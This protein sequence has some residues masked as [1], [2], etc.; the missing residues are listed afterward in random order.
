MTA[1]LNQAE[2]LWKTLKAEEK[3]KL[4]ED[5]GWELIEE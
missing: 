3:I 1:K 4:L 2:A 5:A